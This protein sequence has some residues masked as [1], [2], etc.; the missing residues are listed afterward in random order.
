M[1]VK[2]R[3]KFFCKNA[4]ITISE[5]EKTLNVANGYVNSISKSVGKVLIT[6]IIKYDLTQIFLQE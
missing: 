3:I 1:T 6:T 5:F 2:D 4:N